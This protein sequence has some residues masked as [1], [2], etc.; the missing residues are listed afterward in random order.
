MEGCPPGGNYPRELGHPPAADLRADQHP[1]T[2]LAHQ[3]R[4]HTSL[5]HHGRRDRAFV[6]AGGVPAGQVQARHRRANLVERDGWRHRADHDHRRLAGID[7]GMLGAVRD[8]YRLPR[9]DLMR[10]ALDARLAG[11][12]EDVQHFLR[13]R[14]NMA[15]RRVGIEHQ[16]I[17]HHVLG[18]EVAVDQPLQYATLQ[19][20]A[21]DVRLMA[22][23]CLLLY[24]HLVQPMIATTQSLTI[25][26]KGWST[27]FLGGPGCE[28]RSSGWAAGDSA[29]SA[30]RRSCSGRERTR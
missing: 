25:S 12:L 10:G 17:G 9:A 5:I 21:G 6:K 15:E 18:S 8:E 28:S 19:R 22:K 2:P 16:A 4:R 20:K 11:P 23:A 24:G 29:A 27:A 1:K 7:V 26:T 13:A 30:R 3:R 14:V